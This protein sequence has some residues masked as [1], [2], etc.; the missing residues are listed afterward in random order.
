MTPTLAPAVPQE[1]MASKAFS[2]TRA[3][4]LAQPSVP[5]QWARF[6]LIDTQF[7]KRQRRWLSLLCLKDTALHKCLPVPEAKCSVSSRALLW[8]P[9]G[10]TVQPW[11]TRVF[12]KGQGVGGGG[13][14]GNW[15]VLA[16][17]KLT[18]KASPHPVYI[19]AFFL[20]HFIKSHVSVLG[21]VGEHGC[22]SYLNFLKRYLSLHLSSQSTE[23]DS[24]S[25]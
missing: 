13:I 16:Y 20:K 6:V 4:S 15:K 10:G 24:V 5:Q 14:I 3:A 7:R 1:I 19:L 21:W 2:A 17:W 9:L 11:L 22:Y 8:D 23:F 25:P 18:K 12:R